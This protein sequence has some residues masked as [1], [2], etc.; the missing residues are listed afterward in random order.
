MRSSGS[1]RTGCRF[2][3]VH[4]HEVTNANQEEASRI[5]GRDSCRGI[6]SDCDSTDLLRKAQREVLRS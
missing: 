4:E 1:R 3:F 2:D 5:T 6:R